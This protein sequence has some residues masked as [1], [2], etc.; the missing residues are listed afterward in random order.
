MDFFATNLVDQFLAHEIRR[1]EVHGGNNTLVRE[2][3]SDIHETWREEWEGEW[4][5]LKSR[6]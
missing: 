3:K 5:T 6:N 2:E 1:E 4:H